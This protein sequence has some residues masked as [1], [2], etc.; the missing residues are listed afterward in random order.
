MSQPSRPGQSRTRPNSF[1]GG[2]RSTLTHAPKLGEHTN[3]VLAEAGYT[4]A[5]IDTMRTSGAAR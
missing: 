4:Q 2:D 5:Q 3:D 1:S